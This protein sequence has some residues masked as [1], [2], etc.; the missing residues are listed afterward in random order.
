[1]EFYPNSFRP[2]VSNWLLMSGE[3]QALLKESLKPG[4]IIEIRDGKTVMSK[5]AF[6]K[7]ITRENPSLTDHRH[8]FDA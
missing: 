3:P 5:E 1:M 8:V 6:L 7:L 4:E 2:S